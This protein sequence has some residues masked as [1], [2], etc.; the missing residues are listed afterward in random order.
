MVRMETERLPIRRSTPGGNAD[1]TALI[2]HGVAAKMA[3][4]LGGTVPAER[5]EREPAEVNARTDARQ[6]LE[7]DVGA[8][9]P[10]S[11][12]GNE[13]YGTS[14]EPTVENTG[15]TND[16]EDKTRAESRC[17]YERSLPTIHPSFDG[18]GEIALPAQH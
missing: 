16:T 5:G 6:F 9:R 11:S 14:R 7:A 3:I 13:G 8:R 15:N 10:A 4:R 12:H 1:R 17:R 2:S 18:E